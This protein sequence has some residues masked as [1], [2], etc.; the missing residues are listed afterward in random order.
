MSEQEET[1]KRKGDAD[2]VANMNEHNAHGD[3]GKGKAT[4]QMPF[5]LPDLWD[6][7]LVEHHSCRARI[8][9]ALQPAVP[10]CSFV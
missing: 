5:A 10:C 6:L 2:R 8:D 3:E 7:F 1:T 4:R 9:T